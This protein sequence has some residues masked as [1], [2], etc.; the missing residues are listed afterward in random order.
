MK[1]LLPTD[2]SPAALAAVHHAL[3]LRRE[4]LPLQFVL[5]NVQPPA[6]LYE[7]VVTHDN[8]VLDEIKRGAGADLLAPA[9]TLLD[10]A[11]A[12][13]ESEVAS[14][15]PETL[16]LELLENYGCEAV[17]VGANR[18]HGLGPVATALLTHSP[19]PVTLVR[20]EEAAD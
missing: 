18:P 2:G 10:A 9:E 11:Q 4:G 1:V 8:E 19:V 15:A 3:H 20:Y 13:Y 12:D 16:L 6:T 17:I 14:G 5:I 7:V